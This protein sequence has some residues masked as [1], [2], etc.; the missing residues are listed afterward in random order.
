[1]RTHLLVA[2]LLGAALVAAAA[3]ASAACVNVSI[4]SA[5]DIDGDGVPD[6]VSAGA[7]VPGVGRVDA[8]A[9]R[10]ELWGGTYTAAGA[11]V[12]PSPS[13]A[14]P[15]YNAVSVFVLCYDYDSDDE[16]DFLYAG[17]GLY[18]SEGL[19]QQAYVQRWQ[20]TTSLCI[21]GNVVGVVDRCE[22]LPV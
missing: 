12:S 22:P 19:G 16:C 1:M 13:P 2:S 15:G 7:S 14:F 10:Y 3:P 6:I 21:T 18:S 8:V 20:D 5:C 11:T 9:Y 17:G 4:A